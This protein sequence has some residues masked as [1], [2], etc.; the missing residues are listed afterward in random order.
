MVAAWLRWTDRVDAVWLLP[1]WRHA[2]GKDLAPWADRLALCEALVAQLGPWARVE[3]LEAERGGVSY[4]VDTL[5]VLAAR[6]PAHTF[7]LVVGADVRA[8]APAWKDWA[9]IEA[10][11]PPIVVGRDGFPPVDGA[12]TFPA[13]ASTDIRAALAEG[14]DVSHLVPVDVLARIRALGLY[15]ARPTSAMGR[16]DSPRSTATARP[17]SDP[18]ST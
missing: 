14:R 15:G 1:T 4:T 9:T 7:R 10:R 3:P 17:P 8:Q 6:H 5:G 11:W 18:S 2:F 12:P 16:G 13:I